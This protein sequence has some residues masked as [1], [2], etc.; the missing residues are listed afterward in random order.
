MTEVLL[1]V[2]AD[3]SSPV[4]IGMVASYPALSHS[5]SSLRTSPS[6]TSLISQLSDV[7]SE[8][9]SRH[10]AR[11][12]TGDQLDLYASPRRTSS[13]NSFFTARELPPALELPSPIAELPLAPL[14][15]SLIKSMT[16]PARVTFTLAPDP[17]DETSPED[18]RSLLGSAGFFDSSSGRTCLLERTTSLKTSSKF[19]ERLLSECVD[20]PAVRR[21]KSLPAL[22]QNEDDAID[23]VRQMSE[24]A[25][26]DTFGSAR[27]TRQRKRAIR[28][29]QRFRALKELVTTE[30]DYFQ[31]LHILVDV[32]T[33]SLLS[34]RRFTF[35]F[36]D[37]L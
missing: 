37:L 13:S 2:S 25:L 26:D 23:I 9:T 1:P 3:R 17:L 14:T 10:T 16:S 19:N 27:R 31:A 33:C 34:Y 7:V 22:P 21:W 28:S 30:E 32:R 20:T 5:T 12:T 18:G 24:T 15:P 29:E 36:S 6:H 35:L 8:A 4:Y 11:R